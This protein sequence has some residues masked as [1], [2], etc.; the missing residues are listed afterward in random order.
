MYVP[1]GPLS[2]ELG[3]LRLTPDKS[4]FGSLR[5]ATS[6]D[7]GV[8]PCVEQALKGTLVVKRFLYL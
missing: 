3:R 7:E 8:M 1:L 5:E 6:S 4:M 2:R